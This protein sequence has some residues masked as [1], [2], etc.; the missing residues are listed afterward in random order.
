[1]NDFKNWLSQYELKESWRDFAL[2]GMMAAGVAGRPGYGANSPMPINSSIQNKTTL[3]PQ[4]RVWRDK[5][6]KEFGT[7]HLEKIDKD[8]AYIRMTKSPEEITKILRSTLSDEDTE[9]VNNQE[10]LFIHGK[11]SP[12][13][14]FGEKE[15]DPKFGPQPKIKNATAI[16]IWRY[17]VRFVQEEEKKNKGWQKTIN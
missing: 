11:K 14:N 6:R 16:Q 17:Q 3:I 12:N 4:I 8:F 7:G 1:M 9:Y 13:N 2:A 10:N 15:F 5:D